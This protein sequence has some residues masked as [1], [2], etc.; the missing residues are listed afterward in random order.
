MTEKERKER[1]LIF[2]LSSVS[3][4][5]GLLA[6]I[7][8]GGAHFGKV[9][10]TFKYL[11]FPLAVIIL[12]LIIKGKK[13]FDYKP[14][15]RAI[16]YASYLPIFSYMLSLMAYTVILMNRADT[17]AVFTHDVYVGYMIAFGTFFVGLMLVLSIMDKLPLKLTKF[18]ISLIDVAIII[19]FIVDVLV[20][21]SK[22][23][24]QFYEIELVNNTIWHALSGIALGL[25]MLGLFFLKLR[26]LMLNNE[27][28]IAKDK[29]TLLAEWENRRDD[30]YYRAELV[31][32]YSMFNY[33][34]ERLSIDLDNTD[35][36]VDVERL[37]GKV[38]QLSEKVTQLKTQ[39]RSAVAKENAEVA[40]NQQMI[41]AYTAL[42]NQVKVE[43]ATTELEA[44]K[45]QYELIA[46]TYA[47]MNEQYQQDLASYEQEKQ[48]LLA[49]MEAL[50]K[51]KAEYTQEPEEVVV[52]EP[53]A[54]VAEKESVQ[55]KKEKVF[56]YA[57]E[58]LM[59][60]P[61]TLAYENLSCVANPAGT[62]HKFLIGKKP[63]LITQKTANDYR[64]TFL[65]EDA[66]MANYL[67]GFPGLIS[68]AS[69]PKGGNWL[70]LINRGELEETFIKELV[71]KSL[72]A[73]INAEAIALAAKEE[74]KR[75]KEEA[76]QRE[77]E[78][79][80]REKE[81]ARREKELAAEER[82]AEKA[83]REAEKLAEKARR[84][85]EEAEKARREAE[86][87]VENARIEAE[88]HVENAKR[89]AEEE[90][91]KARREAEEAAEKT[92]REAEEVAEKARREAE[93]AEK[94]RRE[95]ELE[96]ARKAKEAE[97]LAK[98]AEREAA[99]KAKAAEKLVKDAE[100]EAARKAKEAEKLAKDAAKEA[101]KTTK[102][103]EQE[104]ARILA[105][106]AKSS[107]QEEGTKPAPARKPRAK[108]VDV[109]E[110]TNDQK[111]A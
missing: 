82:A 70:K 38:E 104:A 74:E 87:Q 1:Q 55:E 102:E 83:R 7:P 31:L 59:Q 41:A 89:E 33:S 100:K 39:L 4:V 96:A 97:K 50:E 23:A 88:Q 67:Q 29:E 110:D 62:Q 85:A 79:K 107:A 98:E 25:V 35:T 109:T 86:E 49:K 40:K 90:A 16:S 28:Y 91:E 92:R 60:Y 36:T 76:K 2:I 105:E 5:F 27:E 15:N 69:T 61:V 34:S 21:R 64:I 11:I 52:I 95:A 53:E 68:V 30:A 46:D 54:K 44:T 32:L 24:K 84:E 66:D 108:K 22:I 10:S 75:L 48:E 103:A 99:R 111:V 94:A 57:Y 6:L 37:N 19:A 72:Q 26:E 77:L 71:E 45:K 13:F 20:I 18:E 101:A 81:L 58:D 106:A 80:A 78:R 14:T 51:E 42:K 65:S 8:F 63:F 3:L 56:A 12:S 17:T 73:E 43:L 47:K 9:E 93:E